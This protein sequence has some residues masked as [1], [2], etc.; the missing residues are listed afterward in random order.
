MPKTV[1]M[2][3]ASIFK[4]AWKT[5]GLYFTLINYILRTC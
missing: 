4:V 5:F 2:K 1:L 3:I